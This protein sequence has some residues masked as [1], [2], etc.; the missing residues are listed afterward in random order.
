MSAYPGRM[1]NA[2]CEAA[3]KLNRVRKRYVQAL[4]LSLG[5]GDPI[6]EVY[7]KDEKTIV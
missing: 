3:A 7:V 6:I 1:R 4:D 2:E 5:F